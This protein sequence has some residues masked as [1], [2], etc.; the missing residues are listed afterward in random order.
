M[1]Q[2]VKANVV[3]TPHD[4]SHEA[5]L[6]QDGFIPYE[7]EAPKKPTPRASDKTTPKASQKQK[8]EK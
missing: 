4:A 7:I 1:K 5:Q 3:L 6:L 8:T 2:L